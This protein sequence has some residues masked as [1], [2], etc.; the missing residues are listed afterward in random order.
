M[1]FVLAVLGPL[2]PKDVTLLVPS[3]LPFP[4]GVP[5]PGLPTPKPTR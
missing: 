5:L 4:G 2:L 1:P 3:G